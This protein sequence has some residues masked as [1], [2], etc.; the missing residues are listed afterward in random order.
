LNIE[1]V[2]AAAAATSLILEPELAQY[3][4]R[5]LTR[6]ESLLRGLHGP[7]VHAHP[8]WATAATAGGLGPPAAITIARSTDG[9]TPIE[10][11][12]YL[13]GLVVEMLERLY[14]PEGSGGG[15]SGSGG[16]GGGGGAAA[17]GGGA[18]GGG[19]GTAGGLRI[20]YTAETATLA[21]LRTMVQLLLP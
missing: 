16:G 8:A 17:G 14:A 1:C 12:P 19:G 5:F 7:H 13:E 20:E 4:P 9:F 15:G 6:L 2:A 10:T 21:D 11:I 3:L 18:G